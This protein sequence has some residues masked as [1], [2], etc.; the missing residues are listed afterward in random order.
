MRFI[1][2][3]SSIIIAKIILMMIS[4]MPV[5]GLLGAASTGFLADFIGR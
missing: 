5:G 1:I 3:T 2:N 4:S